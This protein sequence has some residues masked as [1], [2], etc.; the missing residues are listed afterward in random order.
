M[1][2]GT[3]SG[4]VVDFCVT[5]IFEGVDNDDL[6]LDELDNSNEKADLFFFCS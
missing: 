1:L 3:E 4:D 5:H 2:N 6:S